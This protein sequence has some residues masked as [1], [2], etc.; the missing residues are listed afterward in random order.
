MVLEITVRT[1]VNS[2]PFRE[3]PLLHLTLRANRSSS[4]LRKIHFSNLFIYYCWTSCV[5]NGIPKFL[6]AFMTVFTLQ[7][8]L[9]PFDTLKTWLFYLLL[10]LQHIQTSKLYLFCRIHT[11]DVFCVALRPS[12]LADWWSWQSAVQKNRMDMAVVSRDVIKLEWL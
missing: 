9:I 1:T 4:R 10:R 12:A 11:V 8:F 7:I 2:E 3:F 6:A 5:P